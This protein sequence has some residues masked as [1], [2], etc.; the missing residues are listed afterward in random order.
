MLKYLKS[1]SKKVESV[2]GEE[3]EECSICFGYF[4]QTGVPETEWQGVSVTL[5]CKGK[6]KFHLKCMEDW[7]VYK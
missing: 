5:N 6:H 7:T 4:E 1:L 3:K 2:E